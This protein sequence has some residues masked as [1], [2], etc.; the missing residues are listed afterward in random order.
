MTR[1]SVNINKIALLRN[2]RGGLAPDLL[3]FARRALAAGADGLTVHPRADERHITRKDAEQV[4]ASFSHST[5][6]NFEGDL[7]E[8]FIDL[9]LRCRPH[10]CTLVPVTHGE[11]TSHRGWDF[12]RFGFL[13]APT[14]ARLKQAGVRV[15]VFVS[16]EPGA[17]QKAAAVGAD[18]IEI[19]TEPYA[20]AFSAGDS[21]AA[22]AISGIA[23]LVQEA[24]A[25]GVG[26]NAGHDLTLENL[27]PLLAGAPGVLEVSIGHHLV[28]QALVDGFGPTVA[29]FKQI[30]L[31]PLAQT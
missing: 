14:I 28:S 27:G 13:L 30:C 2:S 23:A 31:H 25:V 15:S 9:V 5:E 11:L 18:R 12:D 22:A 6:I 1:L 20:L 7:R 8:D 21:S 4:S 29:A 24:N 17:A 10:Q 26:V 19:Y 3:A 16:P